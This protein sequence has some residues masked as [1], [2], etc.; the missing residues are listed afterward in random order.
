MIVR[1]FDLRLPVCLSGLGVLNYVEGGKTK[2]ALCLLAIIPEERETKIIVGTAK[3]HASALASYCSD[4]SSPALLA[5]MESWLCHG[6]DHWFMAPSE[7][8]AIPESRQKAILERILDP[9]PSIAHPV[10]FSIFD[11]ARTQIVDSIEQALSN[12]DVPTDKLPAVKNLLASE[13]KK[14]D[15]LTSN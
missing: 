6:S 7:W 14:L 11:S 2:R 1:S 4:E 10:E 9:N 3:E 13:K 8:H 15:D 12:G 5:M